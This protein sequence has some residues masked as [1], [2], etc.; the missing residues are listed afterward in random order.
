M[1]DV[2]DPTSGPICAPGTT[3]PHMDAGC[4]PN[5]NQQLSAQNVGGTTSLTTD[6]RNIDAAVQA[7]QAA[8]QVVL[9][10]DNAYDGGGEGHDRYNISLSSDQIALANAVLKV[11]KPT[12]LVMVSG[13]I[14]SLDDLTTTAPAILSVG[15]PGVH[16]AQAIAETIFGDNNPGGKL[17]VTMYH[18]SYINEVDF[19]NM[20]MEAGPGRSYR[21]YTGTPLYPFGFGLSYTTF[22]LTWSPSPPGL[23]ELALLGA[24]STT[25]TCT[26]KNTGSVA[27]DEVVL[28]FFKPQRKSLV[29]LSESNPVPIKQLFGFQRVSLG[30][31]E[32]TQVSFTLSLSNLAL[33]D[34]DGHRSIHPG[35]FDIVFSRGHGQELVA[36]LR[37]HSDIAHPKARLSTFRKWW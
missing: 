18:S 3:P 35:D 24:Q 6:I 28:A 2:A 20:S 21:Y 13:G 19:L 11:G 16:G 30:P 37:V 34:V 27:G 5:I 4:Y 33:V 12:V 26:V 17:P 7:A 10:V 22:S 31:G 15:M 23:T 25:Y 8:D 32:S 29:T 1:V 14:I 36:P 9:V